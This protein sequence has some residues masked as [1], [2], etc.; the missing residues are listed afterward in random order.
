MLGTNLNSPYESAKR[1][2]QESGSLQDTGKRFLQYLE[3]LEMHD[4]EV[5]TLL[6]QNYEKEYLK[7]ES[8]AEVLITMIGEYKLKLQQRL[9]ENMLRERNTV[10]S[11][12]REVQEKKSQVLALKDGITEVEQELKLIKDNEGE[13]LR[14]QM[15][16]RR[17]L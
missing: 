15:E 13:Y 7:V 9:L 10:N 5:D 6:V 4:S 11:H 3:K 8:T 14:L 12:L 16:Y 17:H 2:S 1:L